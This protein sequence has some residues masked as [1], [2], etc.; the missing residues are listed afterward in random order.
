MATQTALKPAQDPI[1]EKLI[2]GLSYQQAGE[3]ERAKR[4]YKQVLK[5]APKNADALHLLGVSY[6]QQG[7]PKRALEYIGKAIAV[8]PNQSPFY[9]NLARTMLDLGTDADSLLAVVNKALTLNPKEREAR[10]IKG[11]AL[12]R[13]QEFAEAEYIFQSLVVEYPDFADAY[14]NFG[15]LLMDAKQEEHAINFFTKV[16]MLDPDNVDAYIQRARCRMKLKQ[17]EPSQYELSEA[18]EKFPGNSDIE[19]EAARLLF[20]MNET[21][22]GVEYAR[23]SL[24]SDPENYHKAITLGV[25]LLMYGAVEEALET[26]LLAQKLSPPDNTTVKWNLSLVYLAN[27][28]L[29]NGWAYHRA[30]FEDP[31]TNVHKRK[32]EVPEWQGEDISDKTVLV[33]TDQGLGDALKSGTMLPE[34]ISRAGKVIVELSEKGAKFMQYSFP[35]A[36]FRR[37]AMNED[38]TAKNSDYDLH[39]N[40]GDMVDFFRQ[41]LDAFKNAPCPVYTFEKDRARAYLNRLPGHEAKPVIGFSWRSKNL[42]ANRAR[43]YLSAPGIAPVLESRDAIFVNLQYSALDKELDFFKA[44]FPERFNV[45]EDVDLFDD[46]L[47]AAALT[48]CCDFVVSANTSVADMA[49]I[50]DVPAIRFGQQEP[51]LLLGQKNPPWYPSMT[52]M[53]PYVDRPCSDF[54]P[55]I[56]AEL[57]RHLE[58]WTPERRNKRL[59]I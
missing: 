28:D 45:L 38:M 55:E 46:L 4:L 29:K 19:H 59:G 51:A 37:S 6:R 21:R 57:D 14:Q 53:H 41:D 15:T 3:I 56:I 54:V 25:C 43:Y 16:L 36:V 39:V 48:A 44:Q 12:T 18:L 24:A 30:R 8:D 50:L 10:N 27:G 52:Y 2:K 26:V 22:K 7:Y 32:F 35:E 31:A 1:R 49:G 20:S 5:K 40:I 34:L 42:A 47:G 11:I 58:D 9:A 33:W 23:K 13:K 17:Y